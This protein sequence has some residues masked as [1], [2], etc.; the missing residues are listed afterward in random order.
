MESII[1]VDRMWGM[2]YFYNRRTGQPMKM[3]MRTVHKQIKFLLLVSLFACQVVQAREPGLKEFGFVS[4]WGQDS[5]I[6]GADD[7]EILHLALRFGFDASGEF[8]KVQSP[9][10]LEFVVE[11]FINPVLSPDS[12]VEVGCGLLLKYAHSI[13][14]YFSPYIEA[15][16]GAVYSTQD[17]VGQ[18]TRWN[19]LTQF[20]FGLH[21]FFR[22]ATSLNIGYRFRHASNAGIEEPNSGIDVHSFIMGFSYFY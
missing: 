21:Y 5:S 7:Y 13:N 10:R 18:S 11:P 1:F 15:G 4:G 3:P 12:N 8:L 2:M 22:E 16:T 17:V 14:S 20:G 6:E 19:F 9:H